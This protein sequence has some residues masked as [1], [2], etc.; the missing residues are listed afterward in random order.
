M[1]IYF[2]VPSLNTQSILGIIIIVVVAFLINVVPMIYNIYGISTVLV[3]RNNYETGLCL[4]SIYTTPLSY[5]A[6]P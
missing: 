4:K 1:I 2:D 5:G 6:F 3:F